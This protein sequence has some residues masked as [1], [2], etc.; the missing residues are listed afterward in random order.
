MT[1]RTTDIGLIY[2]LINGV[3]G[4][5]LTLLLYVGGVQWFTSPVAYLGYAIP[6]VIAC[7]GAS[8]QK[9]LQSG[10][11]EFGE[12]LKTV[13]L[14]FVTGTLVNILF[15]YILF[16]IIDV[17]FR[18]AMMQEAATKTERIM[19]KLG[20][21]QDQIDKTVDQMINGNNYTFGKLFLGFAIA[22]IIWFIISLIIAAIMKKSKPEFQ[23]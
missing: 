9:K 13:F 18:Q 16:N 22:C 7:L 5:A 23:N 6:I 8:R 4:I 21:P 20:A 19:Q 11:L 10:F 3:A 15:N 2:G 17:P 14:I 1:K 12:A